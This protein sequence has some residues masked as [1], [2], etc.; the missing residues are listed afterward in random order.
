MRAIALILAATLVWVWG[1]TARAQTNVLPFEDPAAYGGPLEPEEEDAFDPAV[2]A[3]EDE[4]AIDAAPV[5]AEPRVA[6]IVGVSN[7]AN[8][9]PLA[10]PANDARAIADTL[11][12]LGFDV[13]LELDPSLR[14]LQ[15]A[16]IGLKLSMMAAGPD[17]IGLFYF[18]GHGIQHNGVNYLVPA[19][20]S[21]A[22]AEYLDV[23]SV[24]A[25]WVLGVMEAAG[26]AAN[27]I[28]LDA[29][30][31]DPFTRSWRSATR[32]HDT[33]GLAQMQPPRGSFL[34]FS[35]APGAVAYD[36][37]EGEN[38]P[39]AN[40]LI[41]Q[42]RARGVLAE[43]MF[44]RV[45]TDVERITSGLQS[46][47]VQYSFSGDFYFGGP[48]SQED[49]PTGLVSVNALE[50]MYWSEVNES[51]DA[52]LLQQY[53]DW[54]PEGAFADDARAQLAA[55]TESAEP[56]AASAPLVVTAA[57]LSASPSD[58]E[59]PCPT[60]VGFS[61]VIR[62][63]GGAEAE[64]GIVSYAFLNNDGETTPVQSTSLSADGTAE[65]SH[66]WT[67]GE[68]DDR[69]SGWM[70]LEVREPDFLR[71]TRASFTVTCERPE[72]RSASDA[73]AAPDDAARAPIEVP[74]RMVWRARRNPE[75]LA[76]VERDDPALAAE[77]RRLIAE[78]DAAAVAVG[79][80]LQVAP[81]EDAIFAVTPRNTAF[82]WEPVEG[83]RAY[84]I[85]ID[86]Y[87]CCAPNAWCADVGGQTFVQGR[88]RSTQFNHVFVG[89]Q[90]GRWRVQAIL[91]GGAET[92]M[93]PWRE[94]IHV[95]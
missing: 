57:E 46:P 36:G 70:M 44:R 64:A 93:S 58:Y 24:S 2:Y 29:C 52:S 18:A 35:T 13:L 41:S 50:A 54:F 33:L 27:F 56:V 78:A 38:S 3:E 11:R 90:P 26:V 16:V 62:T 63:E 59:G 79:A 45:V 21:L 95:D 32:A 39:F 65:V 6:L 47:W 75:F 1:E 53:L 23:E 83:A 86:C 31:N 67:V 73:G 9:S 74:R 55:L 22:D 5:A 7:Y 82:E 85:E 68:G 20:A 81:A 42:I 77:I 71:S 37:E 69:S 92:P 4:T 94:F 34:V 15:E 43:T 10:N 80:P 76:Q 72:T 40:A 8:A 88:I 61:G 87:G 91:R 30:R 12:E 89:A 84:R 25:N 28:V 14:D 49:A 19:D 60:S 48:P 66:S 17:A 51:G